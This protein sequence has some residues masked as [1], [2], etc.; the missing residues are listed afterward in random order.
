MGEATRS[1]ADSRLHA[2]DFS[3]ERATAARRDA[4]PAL[5]PCRLHAGRR[6]VERPDPTLLAKL[7][8]RSVERD[9]PEMEISS[10]ELENVAHDRRAVALAL[11]E[12]E[13]NVEPVAFHG[14][15]KRVKTRRKAGP[16]LA[17]PALMRSGGLASG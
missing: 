3:G 10:G 8:E 17:E 13:Q 9:R 5:A 6:G 11:G 2:L 12:G 14:D 15:G 1:Y 4:K 7:V 16:L